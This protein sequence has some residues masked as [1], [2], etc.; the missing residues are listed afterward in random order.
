MDNLL[1]T[2]GDL[3]TLDSKIKKAVDSVCLICNISQSEFYSKN[4]ARHL[5][6]ARRFVYSYCRD[7]LELRFMDIAKIFE[8]NHATIMHHVRV[9]N[10]LMIY[11][12]YYEKK[13]DSFIELVVAKIEII[14]LELKNIELSLE[15]ITKQLQE[16][17][18]KNNIN[19]ST[20]Q[21]SPITN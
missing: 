6:D 10:E 18:E 2:I 9:H 13:Y 14:D 21:D 15:A 11:D 16:F 19:E 8:V 5:I 12:D 3:K 4:R 1:K 20:R 17:K 7:N